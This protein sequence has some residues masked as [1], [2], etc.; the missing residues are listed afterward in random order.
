MLSKTK[1][2]NR[3][4]KDKF[5]E[6]RQIEGHTQQAESMFEGRGGKRM[7]LSVALQPVQEVYRGDLPF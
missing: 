2:F 6:S 7:L 3:I 1:R 4:L 5:A